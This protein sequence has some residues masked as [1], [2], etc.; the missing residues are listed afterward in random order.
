[1]IWC[2]T[3]QKH[4]TILASEQ[5]SEYFLDCN[6]TRTIQVGLRTSS[7]ARPIASL[8]ASLDL[9]L[10]SGEKMASNVDASGGSDSDL[11]YSSAPE[12]ILYNVPPPDYDGL[13]QV[14]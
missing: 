5:E 12:D 7:L 11:A 13:P 9:V 8:L 2:R 4:C 1:M 14:L 10:T 6:L 3:E